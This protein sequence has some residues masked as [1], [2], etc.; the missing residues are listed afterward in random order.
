MALLPVLQF[1]GQRK[2]AH[3]HDINRVLKN[4]VHRPVKKVPG[5]RLRPSSAERRAR[6]RR[7]EAYLG[8]TLERLRLERKRFPQRSSAAIINAYFGQAG[9]RWAFFNGL[10]NP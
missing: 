9:G 8:S 4:P 10:I 7:V 3:A 1:K 6:N 2:R 5:A